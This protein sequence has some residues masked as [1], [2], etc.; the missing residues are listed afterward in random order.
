MIASTVAELDFPGYFLEGITLEIFMRIVLA[1]L[2]GTLLGIERE[3]HGRAAGLRTTLLVSLASCISMIIS[4]A[5]YQESFSRNPEVA[6]WHPD[7]ARL[8]AGV[9]AG[10]GFLGAGVIIRQSNHMVRGVTTAAT[11]WFVTII[12]IAFGAGAIGVGLLATVSS[13]LIL[14]AVPYLESKIRIDWYSDISVEFKPSVCSVDLLVKSLVP[15]SILVKGVDI[16]ED[17]ENDRCLVVL[18]VRYKRAGMVEFTKA[19]TGLIREVPG[20]LKI[21]IKS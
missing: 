15:L 12:G 17:L 2:A 13:L 21:A 9:L 6:S 8:A 1:A 16:E 4:D 18:H 3:K 7:P 11:I 10:M 14:S 19:I 20:V 5:F